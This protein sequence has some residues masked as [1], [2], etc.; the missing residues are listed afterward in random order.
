LP[1]FRIETTSV[2]SGTTM[3][4]SGELD[5]AICSELTERFEQVVASG[6]D[7]VV[8]DLAEISFMDSAGL[9]AIIM[10]ER[11]ARERGIAVTIHSPAGPAAD[12][13]QV[14]GI[15]EHVALTPRVGDAPP[16]A[17]FTERFEFELARERTAP[18]R[19]RAELREAIAG[20]LGESESATLTLLTSELV[21]N[22]VIHSSRDAEG[23][24]GL[25]I[26]DYADRVRVEV[27]D[28][29]SGFEVGN[30][31]PRPR[32]FGGHGLVVVEGLSSRWGTA[33]AGGGGGGFCVWFELDVAAEAGGEAGGEH[34]SEAGAGVGAVEP[35]EQSVA[36]EG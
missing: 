7:E 10:I 20:R 17:P 27:T 29:G 26:T 15:G 8:L 21:T 24:I 34:A 2:G 14:T 30:L 3:K 33:R 6:A 5:S 18:G 19:A 4:L 1:N 25:R 22:A 23:T 31:P 16:A 11:A 32:D 28:P 35:A 9:R 36:A 13:L 12:L